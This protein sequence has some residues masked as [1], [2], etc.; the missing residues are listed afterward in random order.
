M[1][2]LIEI[3]NESEPLIQLQDDNYWMKRC[4]DYEVDDVKPKGRPKCHGK[5]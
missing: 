2:V 5:R 4:M 3:V 1:Y